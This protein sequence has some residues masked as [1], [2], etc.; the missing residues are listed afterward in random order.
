MAEIT[1][2]NALINT[3]GSLPKIGSFAPDFSLVSKD[4][5]RKSLKDFPQNL[6]V[7][8]AVPSL[9]TPVCLKST[10]EFYKKLKEKKDLALLVISADLPFAA[11]RACNQ[12]E[13]VFTLSLMN[14]PSFAKDYGLLIVD[15]PLK[16]LCAR[17]LLILDAENQVLYTELV[18]EIT[19]EPDYE[20]LF[21]FIHAH[22]EGK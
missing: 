19:H 16:G 4:L 12:M 10:A 13:S 21:T 9:D 1:L 5:N 11:A 20:S 15:G 14:D 22:N 2:K 3:S 8:Y 6:K 17:A 18:K 7:L